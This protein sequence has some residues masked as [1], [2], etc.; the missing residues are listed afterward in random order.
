MLCVSR[1]ADKSKGV[2]IWP[3]N[4]FDI[5]IAKLTLLQDFIQA[6]HLQWA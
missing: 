2:T 4:V 1:N 6:D 3:E 5:S